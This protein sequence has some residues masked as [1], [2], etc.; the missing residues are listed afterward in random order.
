VVIFFKYQNILVDLDYCRHME[1]LFGS[2]DAAMN[3]V[4]EL[5]EIGKG[6]IV[7]H[8]KPIDDSGLSANGKIEICVQ[9]YLFG[10]AAQRL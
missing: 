2:S 10:P 6:V 5:K 7:E 4:S 9:K 8:D 1:L 3:S